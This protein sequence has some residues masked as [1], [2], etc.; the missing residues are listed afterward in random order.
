MFCMHSDP[1]PHGQAALMLCESVALILIE[2]GVIAKEQMLEAIGGV[3]DV[4]REMAGTDESVVVSVRSIS[5]L[6]AVARSLSAAP[7]P[8]RQIAS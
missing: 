4:K 1:D 2:R 8:L 6:Q 3:I 5:L 7:D